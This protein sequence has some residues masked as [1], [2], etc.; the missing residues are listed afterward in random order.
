MA[1]PY[2]LNLVNQRFPTIN[3][4]ERI[5][6]P[7]PLIKEFLPE[8]DPHEQEERRL[9]YVA[10]TRAKDRLYFTAAKYYG[11]GKMEKKLS[12]FIVE[13]LGEKRLEKLIKQNEKESLANLSQLSLLSWKKEDEKPSS[14]IINP[15]VSHLSFSQ[16]DSFNICPLQYKYKYIIRLPTLPSAAQTTGTTIHK[17]LK[18]F[19]QKQIISKEKLANKIFLDLLNE[20][21]QSTGFKSKSHEKKAKE[22]A[23]KLLTNHYNREIKSKPIPNIAALEQP[24]SFRIT[25]ALRM[26]GIIDRVDLLKDNQ[27]EIIDYKTGERI[28]DQKAVDRNDQ[29]TLYALAASTIS[30]FSFIRPVEKITLSLCFL[31]EGIKLSSQRS[32]EQVEELK[33]KIIETAKEIEKSSFPPKPGKIFPC[34]YCEYKLLCDAWN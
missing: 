34:Q 7:Q 33:D 31:K 19:Y 29:L 22:E 32:K 3:R 10:M 27:I 24:F 12:P 18:E 23:K 5:P 9:F 14:P 25:P 15:P 20:N 6:V 2:L 28:P 17:T 26:G 11:E 4:K 13:S 8:G 30:D 16:M 1:P 21:W